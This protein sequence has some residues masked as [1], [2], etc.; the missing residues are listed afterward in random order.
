MDESK[1]LFWRQPIPLTGWR[2]NYVNVFKW[3]E[4]YLYFSM[5]PYE[6]LITRETLFFNV[7]EEAFSKQQHGRSIFAV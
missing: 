1:S 3:K 5:I 2:Q 7:Y 6:L 4:L